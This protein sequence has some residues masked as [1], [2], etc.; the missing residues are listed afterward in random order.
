M[1]VL[2]CGGRN[3]HDMDLLKRTIDTVHGFVDCNPKA[4]EDNITTII[5]GHARGADQLGESYATQM[6]IGLEVYRAEWDIYGKSA[7][8]KRNMR[9]L[10]EG[11]PDLVIAFPGGRGTAMMVRIAKEADVDVMEVT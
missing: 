5:S 7:G 6:G 2:V 9:M 10:V 4:C 1:R 3:F 11:Q 8:Y